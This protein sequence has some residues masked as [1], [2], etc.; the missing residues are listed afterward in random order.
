M[1]PG[2]SPRLRPQFLLFGAAAAQLNLAIEVQVVNSRIIDNM[3][4][5]AA[6]A[7]VGGSASVSL[8]MMNS[9]VS[10]NMVAAAGAL[11]ISNFAS[12][13]AS[14]TGGSARNN[15][16]LAAGLVATGGQ[17]SA[18]ADFGTVDGGDNEANVAGLPFV[19]QPVVTSIIKTVMDTGKQQASLASERSRKGCSV[20]FGMT[21]A[22]QEAAA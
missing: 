18:R 12:A 19:N 21:G 5:A 17:A 16:L 11:A 15:A 9:D 14:G 1:P 7:T 6:A 2:L 10:G 13:S 20:A 3:L 4:V 8:S 22:A